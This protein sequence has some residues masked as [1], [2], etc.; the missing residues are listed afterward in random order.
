MNTEQMNYERK[1]QELLLIAN[2]GKLS[3]QEYAET[4]NK[5]KLYLRS[6]VSESNKPKRKYS[7][8]P[9]TY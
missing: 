7:K 2:K 4:I 3:A 6:L 1:A 5:I 9:N 8:P